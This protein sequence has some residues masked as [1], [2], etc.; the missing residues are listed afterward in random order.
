MTVCTHEFG[1][2]GSFLSCQI[3]SQTNWLEYRCSITICTH[4]SLAGG[5]F[6]VMANLE[7][8]KSGVAFWYRPMKSWLG[9]PPILHTK[10]CR[11]D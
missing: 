3:C 9:G 5:V 10:T 4:D 1:W 8:Y 11:T 2:G 7:S 6:L